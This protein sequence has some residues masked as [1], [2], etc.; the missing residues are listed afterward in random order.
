M[1][2]CPLALAS[3]SL[4]CILEAKLGTPIEEENAEGSWFGWMSP[5]HST[6]IFG[7]S[8][9]NHKRIKYLILL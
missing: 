4:S 2:S 6:S 8:I 3:L 5:E 7:R 1:M 9:V